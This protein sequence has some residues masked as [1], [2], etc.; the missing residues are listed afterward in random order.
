VPIADFTI[1]KN[2]ATWF[3][4]TIQTSDLSEGNIAVWNWFSPGSTSIVSTGSNAVI[5]YPEGITGTYPIT[6]MVT[7][8]EGCSDSI[9]LEIEIVPDIIIYAPN[10][11]TPDD[12]EHNQSWL[13]YINGID[14]ENFQ[15]QIYNRWGEKIWESFDASVAWDG[16]YNGQSVQSGTYTWKVSYKVKD[17]DGKDF[18]TG[19]VNVLR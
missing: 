16:T 1:S 7:T 14:F 3:E 15:L 9:T 4:T 12:D 17:N 10:T 5:T 2:P 18:K 13:L 11:F 6:L 19:F 8:T